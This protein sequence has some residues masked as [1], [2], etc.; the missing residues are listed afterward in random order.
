MGVLRPVFP[1]H[2]ISCDYGQMSLRI[3]TQI[4]VIVATLLK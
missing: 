2:V 4:Y 3:G 1:D